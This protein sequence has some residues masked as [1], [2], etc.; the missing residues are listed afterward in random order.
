MI[1]LFEGARGGGV[2]IFNIKSTRKTN[3]PIVVAFVNVGVVRVPDL[4]CSHGDGRVE[5]GTSASVWDNLAL[6][7]PTGATVCL[8]IVRERGTS[9][10]STTA[11]TPVTW[12]SSPSPGA[13]IPGGKLLLER[14]RKLLYGGYLDDDPVP[15]CR[16]GRGRRE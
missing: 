16:I 13:V 12:A 14:D 6:H 15:S 3:I 4:G 7:A 11:P 1:R 10:S 8:L 9:M 2:P 5:R